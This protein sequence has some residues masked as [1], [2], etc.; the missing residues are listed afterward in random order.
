MQSALSSKEPWIDQVTASSF[1]ALLLY[2][3]QAWDM[4]LD[5]GS[6]YLIM[7]LKYL[8][9]PARH[10]SHSYKWV[11]KLLTPSAAQINMTEVEKFS[12]TSCLV[13]PVQC[14]QW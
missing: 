7:N 1:P 5:L 3:G 9:L 14:N 6:V 13:G 2:K 10:L 8:L 4:R 11:H 12:G